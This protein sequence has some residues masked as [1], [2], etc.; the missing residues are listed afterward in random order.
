ME[1]LWLGQEVHHQPKTH[2]YNIKELAQGAQWSVL[3]YCFLMGGNIL[4]KNCKIKLK[5]QAEA[6]PFSGENWIWFSLHN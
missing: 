1:S 3:L 2:N 5:H 6:K 4:E